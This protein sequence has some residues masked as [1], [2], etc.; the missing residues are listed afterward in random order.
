MRGVAIMQQHKPQKP[1]S[2]Q[3]HRALSTLQTE[4]AKA[5]SVLASNGKG[6]LPPPL[7]LN[8]M[9]R[10]KFTCKECGKKGTKNN[11]LTV[12]HLGGLTPTKELNEQGHE[13][14]PGNIV[15]VCEKC[16]DRIHKKATALG[17]DSRQVTPAGDKGTKRD[18][19]L[20]APKIPPQNTPFVKDQKKL[21]NA[22]KKPIGRK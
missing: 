5:G 3:D 2:P 1:L 6:G 17:I 13:N 8:V 14:K 21:V 20:P 4:A 10:D 9:R 12:H 15:S 19:G 7:V 22:A 16:H 18:H 11:G